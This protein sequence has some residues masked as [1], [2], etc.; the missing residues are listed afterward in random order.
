MLATLVDPASPD[1]TPV[2]PRPPLLFGV[3][4]LLGLFGGVLLALAFEQFRRRIET[5]A[6]VAQHTTAPVLGRLDRQRTLTRG[7]ASLIWDEKG[8]DDLMES[9]RALRTNV[10]F[11]M[12]DA[13][14][15]VI[16][17]T[18][19]EAAQGKSTVVANLA[20]AFS[21]IG[22][23]TIVLDADLRRPRQHEIFGLDNSLRALEHARAAPQGRAQ[24]RRPRPLGHHQRPGAAGP[25]GDA[26][27]PPAQRDQ[28]PAA[29]Q[30]ADPDRHPAGA[31]GQRCAPRGAAGRRCHPRCDR[32]HTEARELPG[33]HRPPRAR[34]LAPAR[35]VLNK[36]GADDLDIG[37]YYRYEA[38]GETA[39]RLGT[40]PAA[41]VPTPAT[42]PPRT[43][44]PAR[45]AERAAGG[46][47][48]T[49]P[50]VE[51]V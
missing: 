42:P 26:P 46:T 50:P 43:A 22:I 2:Q 19:P 14:N 15:H 25:D 4:G 17:V 33:R 38:T 27:H 23:P 36:A 30:G 8:A 12:D 20:V 40:E 11:L 9:Y 41:R 18:S 48:T 44:A 10:E 6:D 32:R 1:D 39:E 35:R 21:R 3:A 29:T 49:A 47:R 34:R 45:T 24:A 51:Q 28:G 7:T 37:S 16:E 13:T 5:A 31:P